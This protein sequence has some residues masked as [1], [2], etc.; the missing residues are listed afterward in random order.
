MISL[1]PVKDKAYTLD[2]DILMKK[3][4]HRMPDGS[5]M[6]DEDHMKKGK[7]GQKQKQKQKQ[8]VV[9]RNVININKKERKRRPK[10]KPKT[11]KREI[12]PL[13][14]YSISTGASGASFTPFYPP[15]PLY[16]N[17]TIASPPTTND[18][19]T[20]SQKRTAELRTGTIL[21]KIEKKE[22][23]LNPLEKIEQVIIKQKEPIITET[24]EI[25]NEEAQPPSF[26]E[27]FGGIEYKTEEEK[28]KIERIKS[29]YQKGLT[30]KNQKRRETYARKKIAEL[31]KMK[32]RI[33]EV[34]RKQIDL[35]LE[36]ADLINRMNEEQKQQ[37]INAMNKQTTGESEQTT[38]ESE[39]TPIQTPTPKKK[40]RNKLEME[41]G[42][43]MQEADKQKQREDT[44]KV[45]DDLLAEFDQ[46]ELEKIG[47]KEIIKGNSSSSDENMSSRVQSLKRGHITPMLARY[48]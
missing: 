12:R 32:E 25:D 27:V 1:Q 17:M 21:N 38:G 44:Q 19:I 8:S 28:D 35:L 45:Y 5:M 20:K 9:I 33:E 2:D 26:D 42:K 6:R 3:G 43:M 41:E 30:L 15:A 29:N 22:D 23:A 39:P 48:I 13:P 40:R 18:D 11:E 47:I 31:E 4:Y 7:R 14:S 16:R 34:E 46:D 24:K 36:S 10:P 37:V